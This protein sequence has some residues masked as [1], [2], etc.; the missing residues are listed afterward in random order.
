M[1]AVPTQRKTC[2]RMC[3]DI[4][5]PVRR[6]RSGPTD[7]CNANEIAFERLDKAQ[8]IGVGVDVQPPLRIHPLVADDVAH[9]RRRPAAAG[10]SGIPSAAVGAAGSLCHPP[11]IQYL[12][13]DR[14]RPVQLPPSAPH[15]AGSCR[16]ARSWSRSVPEA[17][18][19]LH[20]GI[21]TPGP[22]PA[23][24]RCRSYGCR[25]SI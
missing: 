9:D 13:G 19:R 1:A 4:G 3:V 8:A 2:R 10:K 24:R 14:P 25:D 11:I 16:R 15:A 6:I 21:P 17:A 5:T 18:H 12:G 23:R 7:A 20:D 22:P